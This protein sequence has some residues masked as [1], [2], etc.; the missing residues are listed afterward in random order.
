MK[1]ILE[2]VPFYS[3]EEGLEHI[4]EGGKD[5][6]LHQIWCYDQINKSGHE[7]KFIENRPNTALN[8]LGKKI[9]IKDAFE[10]VW[11]LVKYRFVD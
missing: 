2:I 11:A 10:A 5:I 8:K 4:L 9:G 3:L 1:K 6:P 7:V